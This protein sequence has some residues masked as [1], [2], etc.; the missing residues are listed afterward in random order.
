MTAPSVANCLVRMPRLGGLDRSPPHVAHRAL[1]TRLITHRCQRQC[2]TPRLSKAN[3]LEP[4][5]RCIPHA[6]VKTR[7]SRDRYGCWG[8]HPVQVFQRLS[9]AIRVHQSHLRVHA[10]QCGHLALSQGPKLRRMLV[11]HWVH[12]AKRVNSR[13]SWVTQ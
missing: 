12:V 7:R 1:P 3:A 2:Q 4:P 5:S 9:C 10:K 8:A 6:P 13:L 11:A